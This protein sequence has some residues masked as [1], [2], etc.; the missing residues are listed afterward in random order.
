MRCNTLGSPPIEAAFTLYDTSTLLLQGRSRV[1][2]QLL[3]A[4]R[5]P[6]SQNI[7]CNSI[8]MPNNEDRSRNV[9]TKCTYSA[10]LIFRAISNCSACPG[11]VSQLPA[12]FSIACLKTAGIS[13]GKFNTELYYFG[14]SIPLFEEDNYKWA[15]R[16]LLKVKALKIC[17]RTLT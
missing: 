12:P 15:P 9:Y 2:G 6:C 4:K 7:F 14:V 1:A 10:S 11:F 3:W 17:L 8:V 16:R 5:F 13:W